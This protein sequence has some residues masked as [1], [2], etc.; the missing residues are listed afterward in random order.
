MLF[1]EIVI[2]LLIFSFLWALLSF[3]QMHK[4]NE[5]EHASRELA[6]GRVIF[7]NPQ[8]SKEEQAT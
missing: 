6:K 1:I 4:R 7:Y 5:S 3:K 2:G 8:S